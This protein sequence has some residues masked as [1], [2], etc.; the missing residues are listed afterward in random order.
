MVEIGPSPKIS[1][2]QTFI[3]SSQ[4]GHADH[5]WLKSFHSFSFADYHDPQRMGFGP[6]RVINDDLIAPGTGFGMHGHRDMEILTY[7]LAG[8][9]AHRDRMGSSGEHQGLVQAGDVQRMSAGT[10]VM[11]SE[12]NPSL[13]DTCH[14]LQI[15]IQ[16]HTAGVA[17]RYE[18][19]HFGPERKRGRLCLVA[20]PDG[21]EGSL[22]IHAHARMYAGL[23]D[24]DEQAELA[25][26][27]GHLAYVH[28]ARGSLSVNGQRLAAGDALQLTDTSRI[29]VSGGQ[30]AEVLVFDL[31]A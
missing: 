14:L 11:H 3:S 17:P 10:G 12:V 13:Q 21:A 24:G 16:P 2:M 8:T 22:S 29:N 5:G 9:L 26:P 18:Q 25:L 4:R 7:P 31:G 6:L 27:A 20:S 19:Q 28:L 30:D 23:F 1:A 15:W